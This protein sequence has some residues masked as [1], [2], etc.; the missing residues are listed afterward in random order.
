MSYLTIA[1][2]S[3]D[4]SMRVRVAASAA[5]EGA[6]RK[7]NIDPDHWATVWRRTWAAAPGWAAA[8]D[9]AVASGNPAPGADP[10]VITDAMI[11]SEIQ[12][13]RPF[14]LV[15]AEPRAAQVHTAR[16]PNP[17]LLTAD[18]EE[19]LT[20][21]LPGAGIWGISGVWSGDTTTT[22]IEIRTSIGDE[23]ALRL[24]PKDGRDRDFLSLTGVNT[25]PGP[26]IVEAKKSA[27]AGTFMVRDLSIWWMAAS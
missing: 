16:L 21:D 15:G 19:V 9:S 14:R 12:T 8:W 17:Q 4:P 6:S 20:L 24:E 18:W 23:S 13:Y 25:T 1:T 22:S 27:A 11:R 26:L 10:A 7:D 2:L 5:Q 3:D